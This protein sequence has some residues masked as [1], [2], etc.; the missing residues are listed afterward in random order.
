MTWD[1]LFSNWPEQVDRLVSIFPHADRCALI[2]FR[3]NRRHLAQYL[4]DAHDLTEAEG[5]EAIELRLLPGARSTG[6]IPAA[7]AQPKHMQT[8]SFAQAR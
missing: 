4:A 1:E 8:Q 2:R 6:Q 7:I 5:L 3:G